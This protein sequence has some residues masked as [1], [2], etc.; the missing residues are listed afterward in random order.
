MKHSL[1]KNVYLKY[2][3]NTANRRRVCRKNSGKITYDFSKGQMDFSFKFGGF[4]SLISNILFNDTRCWNGKRMATAGIA[5]AFSGYSSL[6]ILN[7]FFAKI[8]TRGVV[9]A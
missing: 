2:E 6:Y 3:E 9:Y 4:R 7:L 1:K 5:F 8:L